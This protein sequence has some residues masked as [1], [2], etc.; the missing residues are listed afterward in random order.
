ML[1]FHFST[2]GET[3]QSVVSH[4]TEMLSYS[5]IAFCLLVTLL[6]IFF[7]FAQKLLS[8]VPKMTLLN[9]RVAISFTKTKQ[10]WDERKRKL[11]KSKIKSKKRVKTEKQQ[12]AVIVRRRMLNL[13][14]TKHTVTVQR[15]IRAKHAL[16]E[17]DRAMRDCYVCIF[18][19]QQKERRQMKQQQ[20]QQNW[21]KRQKK[22]EK[23]HKQREK[24]NQAINIKRGIERKVIA[25][26]IC[27]TISCNDHMTALYRTV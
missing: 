26:E 17:V 19:W 12:T 13:N 16:D 11:V 22:Q 3:C 25:P 20:L 24:K 23:T 6:D 8:R 9:N 5:A 7:F 27:N 4:S 1:P 21:G 15:L 18:C 2:N 14:E 10:K